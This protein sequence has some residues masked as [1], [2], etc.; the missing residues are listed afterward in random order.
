MKL[1][2]LLIYL[3]TTLLLISCEKS[4]VV[5]E[6]NT[7]V[8]EAKNKIMPLGASR[9]AGAR[10][11]FESYRYELWKKLLDN[12]WDIDF[13][14]TMEDESSYPEYESMAFDNDHE[15]RGGWK[16]GQILNNIEDWLNQSSVPDIVLFSSPG[17]NDALTMSSYDDAISNVNGIIDILQAKNPNITIFIEKLAPGRSSIMTG[18]LLTYFERMQNDVDIISENQSTTNSK[19]I[20]VDMAT[21]FNDSYLADDV[22]YNE[23]GAEFIATR[24]YE[25]LEDILEK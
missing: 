7:P 10:P 12:N 15:G 23:A 19:V 24:Y 18:E 13:V 4:E 3:T 21:G 20:T 16:S 8:V 11:I 22:H 5:G 17:G 9:V 6:E 1:H 25:A 2:L 14:G